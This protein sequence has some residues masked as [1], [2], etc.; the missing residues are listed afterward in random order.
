MTNDLLDVEELDT[1]TLQLDY[2]TLTITELAE[3]AVGQ[4]S[5]LTRNEQ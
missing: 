3:A 2:A 1:G 5:Q 4:V